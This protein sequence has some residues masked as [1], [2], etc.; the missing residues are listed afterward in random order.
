VADLN[1]AGQNTALADGM[2]TLTPGTLTAA[3][4]TACFGSV[5]LAIPA[6]LSGW[7][8]AEV[9]AGFAA[10]AVFLVLFTSSPSAARRPRCCG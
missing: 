7:G 4:F 6:V 10:S 9:V 2:Y 8:S 3:A 1:T 5:A